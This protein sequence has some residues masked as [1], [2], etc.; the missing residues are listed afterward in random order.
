MM[1]KQDLRTRCCRLSEVEVVDQSQDHQDHQDH[2]HQQEVAT[3]ASKKISA[4]GHKREGTSLTGRENL[5]ELPRAA[6]AL[7]MLRKDHFTCSS[8]PRLHVGG[9][10]RPFCN[11]RRWV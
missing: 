9:A 8:K 7:R 3:A 4:G 1:S 11:H 10:T 6:R 2:H 5:E